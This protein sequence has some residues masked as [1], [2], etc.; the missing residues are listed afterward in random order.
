MPVRLIS[1][2]MA[3]IVLPRCVTISAGTDS[4]IRS[5]SR[6]CVSSEGS[7]FS[8]ILLRSPSVGRLQGSADMNVAPV[9]VQKQFVVAASLGQIRRCCGR[10]FD[11]FTEFTLDGFYVLCHIAPLTSSLPL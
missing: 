8:R 5:V 2:V 7:I 3:A 10:F 1:R 11:P 9:R 6:L 4:S